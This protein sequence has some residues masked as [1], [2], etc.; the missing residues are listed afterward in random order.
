MQNRHAK[1]FITTLMLLLPFIILT[2][3]QA[4]VAWEKM[5]ITVTRTIDKAYIV[6]QGVSG[7]SKTDVFAV[8]KIENSSI[9]TN[10][11]GIILHYDGN[12]GNIWKEILPDE[13]QLANLN[14][15]C[16]GAK[17][18]FFAVGDKGTIL[19]GKG[20]EWKMILQ[21]KSYEN[22]QSVWVSPKNT[23]F[24]VGDKGTF[25]RGTNMAKNWSINKTT[26]KQLNAIWGISEQVLFAVGDKGIILFSKNGGNNWEPRINPDPNNHNLNSLWGFSGKAIYAAGDGGVILFSNDGGT[27]WKKQKNPITRNHDLKSIWG[28]S[29]N[30]VFA[31]GT[32]GTVLRYQDEE[33][34]ELKSTT[35]EIEKLT[36]NAI[37]VSSNPNTFIIGPDGFIALDKNLYPHYYIEGFIRNACSPTSPPAGIPYAK[38]CEIAIG[39]P[40]CISLV[41]MADGNGKYQRTAFTAQNPKVRFYDDDNNRKYKNEEPI[42]SLY[43][44]YSISNTTHLI[45]DP[46]VANPLQGADSCI[47]GIVSKKCDSWYCPVGGI[48]IVISQ[49]VN[50]EYEYLDDTTTDGSGFYNFTGLGYGSYKITPAPTTGCT[51]TP[52]TTN[53]VSIPITS[54][55]A[56]NF[57]DITSEGSG[58]CECTGNL[59]NPCD[60][61]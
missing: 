53:V 8:G 17:N 15:V 41:T 5:G 55:A 1:F 25:L 29:P 61:Q 20:K 49:L 24:A 4:Q 32:H 48:Q 18:D 12:T 56:I 16:R 47:A 35:L 38:L 36:L 3:V 52:D 59:D 37:W 26:D 23:I 27:T 21:Q 22:L 58:K 9:E 13:K 51:F 60:I 39:V 43:Q 19:H 14:A 30:A 11:T 42:L 34:I 44:N 40:G 33:W 2:A 28:I 54:P 46:G 31:A 50:C 7:N 57:T 45:P 10:N 6:L